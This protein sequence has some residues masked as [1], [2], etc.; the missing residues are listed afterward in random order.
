MFDSVKF[1]YFLE[2]V[3]HVVQDSAESVKHDM[4]LFYTNDWAELQETP[5]N[6]ADFLTLVNEIGT[7]KDE[8]PIVVMCR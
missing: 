1:L 3:C 6:V 4:N 2:M 7:L 5:T 8:G